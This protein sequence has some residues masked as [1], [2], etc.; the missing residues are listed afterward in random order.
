[1]SF[2]RSKRWGSPRPFPCSKHHLQWGPSSDEFLL[3]TLQHV[4]SNHLFG[5][6]CALCKYINIVV[7]GA[8][9]T[10]KREG[11]SHLKYLPRLPV[12]PY[13]LYYYASIALC[14]IVGLQKIMWIVLVVSETRLHGQHGVRSCIR[15]CGFSYILRKSAL[16]CHRYRFRHSNVFVVA[17]LLHY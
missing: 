1:M 11:T 9:E 14:D 3:G 4:I 15:P 7:E 8:F 12:L 2:K 17:L 13:H 6:S 5:W 10:Q 16:T